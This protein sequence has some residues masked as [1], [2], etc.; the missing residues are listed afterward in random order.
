MERMQLH[1]DRIGGQHVFSGRVVNLKVD[2]IRLPNGHTSIR[3][4]IEHPGGVTVAAL[5]ELGICPAGQ[6]IHVQ[7]RGGE[8]VIRVLP[9]RQL[10]MTGSAVTVYE[11][12]AEV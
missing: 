12:V 5:T 6:D 10:L 1:E 9:G 3:E 7:L 11:G 4:V 2:Q 8:L